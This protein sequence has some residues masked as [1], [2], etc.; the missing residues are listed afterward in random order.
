MCSYLA[1][2]FE[3]V[4][5]TEEDLFAEVKRLIMHTIK[6]SGFWSF[7]FA[8]LSAPKLGNAMSQDFLGRSLPS[9]VG[10]CNSWGFT[11]RVL[12][13]QTNKQTNKQ[14]NDL[15]PDPRNSL[16]EYGGG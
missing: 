6:R 4:N 11:I 13:H 15:K 10:G 8:D 9:A 16:T 12:F 1:C 7:F 5:G 2:F 14:T 3:V